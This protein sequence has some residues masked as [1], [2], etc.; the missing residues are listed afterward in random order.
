[1]N[2]IWSALLG[3]H[4][5]NPP[6]VKVMRLFSLEKMAS[7]LEA[8]RSGKV[9]ILV[10]NNLELSAAQKVVDIM[11]NCIDAING[12]SQWLGEQT[13]LFAP[14]C[15][16]VT[17]TE[18]GSTKLHQAFDSVHL[19][20]KEPTTSKP[21]STQCYLR[22][23]RPFTWSEELGVVERTSPGATPSTHVVRLE[24][25]RLPG[26][27]FVMGS[28]TTEGERSLD[29]GPQHS[30]TIAAFAMGKYPVT[31]AQ[32]RS[33]ASLPTVERPLDPEPACFKGDNLP[34]E[35]VSWDDA[36]EFCAR[37]AQKTGRLYRLPSE[38][39]WEY[40]CRATTTTPFHFGEAIAA[41]LANYD[42]CSSYGSTPG[43]YR[44][45]TTPVGYFKSLN[46][47]GL[48]DLHG[49]VWE[50]C[51]DRWH[52]NYLNAPT[53]GS[54]WISDGY[55]ARVIR[56]GSWYDQPRFCRAACRYAF[57][58]DGRSNDVGFR[59]ACTN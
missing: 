32:W 26:G 11:S 31:Q 19:Q 34:V 8:L 42:G 45:Q 49:N 25:V 53:D 52:D 59:V 6:E 18:F 33:I 47:F 13:F 30:V 12:Q 17:A 36:V 14:N 56:G 48:S 29:E 50:W 55:Q 51:G 21:K 3:R 38:A 37:L 35:R 46:N 2:S 41:D 54:A 22:Q 39:E 57:Q 5:E 4:Q 43:P 9:I 10:L 24:M 40:A 28:P 15:F 44:Q 20:R 1:M 16:Q 27:T 58:P 7:V 23:S